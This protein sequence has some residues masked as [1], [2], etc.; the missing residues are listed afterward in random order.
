MIIGK[1]AKVIESSNKNLIG[2]EGTIV[3]ETQNTILVEQ[4]KGF[5]TLPKT[6]VVLKIDG[7][8]IDCRQLLGKIEDRIKK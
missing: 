1:F 7:K 8:I 6:Q 5:K 4:P 2:I 3:D